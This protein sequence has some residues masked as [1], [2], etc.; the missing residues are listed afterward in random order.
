QGNVISSNG[1]DGILING[2]DDNILEGN[3]IGT[4]V[5]G[6][7]ARGNGG[8][9]VSLIDSDKTQILGTTPIDKDNPFVYSNI[10]SANKGNGLLV[11]NSDD[12]KIFANFFGVAADDTTALGNRGDGVL[13]NGTS[14]G[15]LFGGNIPLGNLSAANRRNGVEVAD[16]ASRT[17]LMN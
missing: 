6:L 10:M 8:N 9:G 12:T 11:H 3:F 17:L 13:I 4:D 2:A 14:D 15:T 5:T 1:G 7:Q 16:L